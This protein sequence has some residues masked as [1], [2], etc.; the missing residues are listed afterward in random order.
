MC[1]AIIQYSMS[2]ADIYRYYSSERV[3]V[4][5]NFVNMCDHVLWVLKHRVALYNTCYANHVI[6]NSAGD[7]A[8]TTLPRDL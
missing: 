3:K 1:V 8:I 5:F 7:T 4:N 6:K 2:E